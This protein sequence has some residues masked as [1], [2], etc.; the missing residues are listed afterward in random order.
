[1][2]SGGGWKADLEGLRSQ[3]LNLEL[4]TLHPKFFRRALLIYK[5]RN[6]RTWRQGR[7]RVASLV[8]TTDLGNWAQIF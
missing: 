8:Q 4:Q 6:N 7:S 3:S 5:T 2:A 1:M